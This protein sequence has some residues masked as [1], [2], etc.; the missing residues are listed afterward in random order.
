MRSRIFALAAAFA[1]VCLAGAAPAATTLVVG[2]AVANATPMEPVNLGQEFGI[3]QKH[4][5]DLKIVDFTGGS[6]LIQA[7][8]AGSVDIGIADGTGMAFTAKGAPIMAICEAEAKMY[9][10]GVA[11]PW[12]SPVH[13]LDGLKG[14][15]IGI[16]S[17]GSF[18][19]FLATQLAEERGWGPDGIT[20]VAI[21]NGIATAIA[22]FRTHAID[23]DMFPTADIF[24]MEEKHQG[25]LLA[26]AADFLPPT[27]AGAIFATNQA[28]AAHPEAIRAFL[29]GWLDTI[30]YMRANRTRSV[31]ALS[32]LTGLSTG[33][34]AKDYDL[35]VPSLSKDC[36]FDAESLANLKRM[37]V[38]QKFLSAA[39]NMSKLYTDAFIP[40]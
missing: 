28:I 4:G 29:A 10:T 17:P 11:V 16:S 12:D 23:A 14:K 1:T 20:K 18:T 37:F 26:V 36:R 39:P 33:A 7:M 21:G 31:A 27:A 6:K 30:Q 5:L 13:T 25:R 15:R 9:P 38:T 3:F 34:M 22:A 40:K 19:D 35:V 2:K 32:K 24:A 8:T